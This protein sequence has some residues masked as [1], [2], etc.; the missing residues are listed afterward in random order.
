MFPFLRRRV[1]EITVDELDDLMTAGQVH[2]V[3]VREDHE[4]RAGHVRGAIPVPLGELAHRHGSLP[5]DR[6]IAVICQSGSRSLAVT[7]FLL[8]RGLDGAASVRGGT[9]AWARSGRP[10]ERGSRRVA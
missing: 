7:E 6:R 10:I 1:P 4:F 8:T 3:D 5:R 9:S 2:V